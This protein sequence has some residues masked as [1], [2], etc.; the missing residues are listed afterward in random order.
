MVFLE[1]GDDETHNNHVGQVVLQA[2]K[3]VDRKDVGV[4]FCASFKTG[5][6]VGD[7]QFINA[8]AKDQQSDTDDEVINASHHLSDRLGR[9]A[10]GR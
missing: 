10:L 5:I 4:L 9:K 3:T 7:H 1:C 2:L 6:Q 8:V